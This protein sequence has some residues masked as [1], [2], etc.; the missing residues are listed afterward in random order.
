MTRNPS[1][2]QENFGTVLVEPVNVRDAELS[3]SSGVVVVVVVV[4][5]VELE[6]VEVT[7]VV[8]VGRMNEDDVVEDVVEEVVVEVVVGEEVEEVVV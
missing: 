5:V 1:V 7:N 4:V 8:E 2:G 6:I 3:T